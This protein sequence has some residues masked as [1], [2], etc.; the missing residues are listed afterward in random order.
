M[1]EV[2]GVIACGVCDTLQQVPV[3]GP[4]QIAHCASCGST[5][6]R[7]SRLDR[8][9]TVPLVLTCLLLFGMANAFPIVVLEMG[10]QAQPLTLLGAVMTLL[11]EGM[12]PVAMLVLLPT[13]LLPGMYL[14]VLLGTLMVIGLSQVP[15][16]LVNR[17]VR[18]MQQIAPWSMVEV[19]LIGIL[20]ATIKLAGTATVVLGPALWAWMGMTI[21][22]TVV[23]T[24]D[25]RR[26]IRRSPVRPQHEAMA[27]GGASHQP[28]AAVARYAQDRAQASVQDGPANVHTSAT[29]AQPGGSTPDGVLPTARGCGMIACHACD[30]VWADAHDGQ[31]CPR[32]GAKLS[33]RRV[34]DLNLTWALLITAIILYVPANVLPMMITQSL[35]GTT[36]DTILS[37]VVFFWQHGEWFIASIIFIASFLIP[38]FKLVALIMLAIQVQRGSAWRLLERTHLYHAVEWVGRWSMLDVFVVAITSALIQRPGVAVVQAGPGIVAF[39]AVVVLTMLAAMSFD[40]RLA[41]DA[42]FGQRRP[43]SGGT[44]C[45]QDV[46]P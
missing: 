3:L 25:L 6:R 30:T 26:L 24:V 22:L 11:N 38:L 20:V 21:T 19:F 13:L 44:M 41:W 34:Y 15:D 12:I 31:L 29:A 18:M 9:R 4:D 39:G 45:R 1:R 43:A 27:G 37:G 16:K 28:M 35:F 32:C 7:F 42:R 23:L 17:M 14:L 8:A 2:G 36:E 33:R 5:L 10:G 46:S 40:P